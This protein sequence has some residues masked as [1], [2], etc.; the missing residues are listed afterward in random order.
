MSDPTADI[1]TEAL[2]EQVVEE[3]DAGQQIGDKIVL[4]KRQLIAIAGSGLGAGAL[5]S[6][7]IDE[8]AAQAAGSQGTPSEPN[9]MYA[10][11]LDVQNGAEFNGNPLAGVGSL[12]GGGPISDG[13]GTERQHYVIANGASD[14]SGADPEDIIF[15]E[16]A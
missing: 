7:G 11:N 5:A 15:E 16:E 13:D 6:L 10:Y 2:A 4:S 14:P 12:N 8:A 9:D 1:D 3:L